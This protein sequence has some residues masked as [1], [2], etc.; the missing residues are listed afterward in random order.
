MLSVFSAT[1]I[2]ALSSPAFAKRDRAMAELNK[3]K[4]RVVPLE[5]Y[6]LT[7]CNNCGECGQPTCLAFATRVVVGK[8]DIDACPFIDK[9]RIQVLRK[10]LDEQIRSGIGVSRESFEKTM[11]F[12]HHEIKKLNFPAIAESLGAGMSE[13]NGQ[14]ALV[15]PYFG[16]SVLVTQSDIEQDKGGDL[17]PWEKILIY[18][19]VIGGG[20]QP[21][22]VWVAMESLPNS[23]SKIKSLQAHCE[24]PLAGSFRGKLYLLSRLISPWGIE[25]SLRDE[26]V[27]FAAEFH[28][29]PKLAIRVL[30]WD[31][32]EDF[33]CRAKFL[34]DSRVLQILDLESLI[35]AC[36][37]IT[38]R[39]IQGGMGI[40]PAASK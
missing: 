24:S 17:S 21:A 34:F 10:R 30:F 33:P 8:E 25:V 22:G 6:K 20:A 36:E 11:E 28:V 38:D 9:A 4:N 27:D 23:V 15:F 19:Y 14:P 7:R 29:F 31:E 26:S 39:L 13:S 35:F 3:L 2:T 18:N 32:V 12:L 1:E 37:Q 16:D 5:L 40:N